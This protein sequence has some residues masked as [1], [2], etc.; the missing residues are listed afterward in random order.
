[1][2][3]GEDGEGI[4]VTISHEDLEFLLGGYRSY[5]PISRTWPIPKKRRHTF[6]ARRRRRPRNWNADCFLFYKTP[7][8]ISADCSRCASRKSCYASNKYRVAG[9]G[10]GPMDFVALKPTRCIEVGD[11]RRV[12]VQDPLSARGSTACLVER[13]RLSGSTS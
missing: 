6:T 8:R 13:E 4:N 2:G 5:A 9:T 11:W 10:D 12:P 3:G 7:A 1:M